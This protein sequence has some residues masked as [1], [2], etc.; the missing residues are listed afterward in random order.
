[1]WEALG[2]IDEAGEGVVVGVVDTG[3]AP[4]HPSFAGEA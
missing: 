4:E 2:G 3:I 1:M